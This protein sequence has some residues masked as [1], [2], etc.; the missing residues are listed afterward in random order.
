MVCTLFYSPF[1]FVLLFCMSE[2]LS[3]VFPSSALR[4]LRHFTLSQFATPSSKWRFFFSRQNDNFF[5][6]TCL[7]VSTHAFS[8]TI[9]HRRVIWN[10]KALSV[11]PAIHART[12]EERTFSS[13]FRTLKIALTRWLINV[14]TAH[15]ERWSTCYLI[16]LLYTIHIGIKYKVCRAKKP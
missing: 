16:G 6:G 11:A 12:K 5:L 2:S 9:C 1:L 4:N 10:V 14:S 3:F 7:F 15:C 8:R 13:V